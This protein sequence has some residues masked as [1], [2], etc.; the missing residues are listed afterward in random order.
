VTRPEAGLEFVPG[1]TLRERLGRGGMGE[2]WRA[3]DAERGDVVAK[4]LP[5]DASPEQR[6]LLEREARIVRKLE[7]PAI[8][9]VYG[10]RSGPHGAALVQRYLP[11][12]DASTLRGARALD[13]VRLA[14]G[15]AA[16]LAHIHALGVVHRDVKPSNVL[17][18][19]HGRACLAD[20]GISAALRVDR[21]VAL[22]GGGSRPYMSPQQRAG[23]PPQPADDAYALGAL[24]RDLLAGS[25]APPALDA[26]VAELLAERPEDRPRDLAHVE[27]RLGEIERR[28]SEPQAPAPPL[29]LRPPP[30]AVQEAM[31]AAPGPAAAAPAPTASMPTAARRA[32]LSTPGLFLLASLAIAAAFVT[33]LLPRFAPGPTAP[34]SPAPASAPLPAEAAPAPRVP[35]GAAPRPP[36]ENPGVAAPARPPRPSR[37]VAGEPR[38][39]ARSAGQADELGAA[40]AEGR[41]ALERGDGEA[42]R[43]SFER[44]AMLAPGNAL[45]AEGLLAADELLRAAALL[46]HRA[47]GGAREESEDWRGA[48][49]EYEAALAVDPH[50]AFAQDGRSRASERARVAEALAF[51]I[52]NPSRLSTDAVAREAESILDRAREVPDPGPRH[53]EQ[54]AALEKALAEAR[55]LVTVVLESD[56]ETEVTVSR[57]GPLGRFRQ[58]S[59]AL[60][61]GR[62]AIVGTRRGY[63][64]VRRELVVPRGA[65]S[66]APALVVRC[67]E[68]I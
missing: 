48:V 13:V 31:I 23:D 37:V 39:P 6:T 27:A 42:A 54:I 51:H 4:L 7:H 47:A 66:P 50:V 32:G 3:H 62:Y 26:L 22:R 45:A 14:R 49:A 52:T 58:R 63:R 46:R 28:L 5:A 56:G 8:V 65:G 24:L 25:A 19:E 17:L 30:R 35:T 67:E 21:D 33:I 16:A 60:R 11:G 41:T 44:A 55:T 64:D 34:A 9:P 12:G 36:A 18:D 38:A 20:F 43:R 10:L 1:L 15:V 2:V 29:A 61:P 59:L 53:R 40:L 68:A 57:V